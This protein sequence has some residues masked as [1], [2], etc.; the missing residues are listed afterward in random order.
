MQRPRVRAIAFDFDGVLVE[1]AEVKTNAFRAMFAMEGP[2]VVRDAVAYHVAHGGVSRMEKLRY[3]YAHI[4]RR[5]LSEQHLQALCEQFQQLV[6]EPVIRAPWVEGA[7]EALKIL[8]RR[9]HPLFVVSGT[10]EEELCLILQRRGALRYF[11]AVYGSPRGKAD[12]LRWICATRGYQGPEMLMIG[13]SVT[14]YEASQVVGARFLARAR[15]EQAAQWEPYGVLSVPDLRSLFPI[16]AQ[17]DLQ[18]A[19]AK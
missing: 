13:D 6:L 3:V 10:P 16:I 17:G 9:N 2:A 18:C 8:R 7:L 11:E 4:L 15:A 1:S 19:A 12:L 5:P 14:D